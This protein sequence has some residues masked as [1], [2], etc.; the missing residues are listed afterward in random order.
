MIERYHN[1]TCVYCG[2]TLRLTIRSESLG[3]K[4]RVTC[5]NCQ[6]GFFDTTAFRKPESKTFCTVVIFVE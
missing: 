5:P 1:M 3:K 4:V 6:G 2:K